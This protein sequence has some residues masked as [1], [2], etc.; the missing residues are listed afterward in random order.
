[1]PC[2]ESSPQL[3]T[4]HL[5]GRQE[6]DRT[7]DD[8]LESLEITGLGPD[9]CE[10]VLEWPVFGQMFDRGRIEALI[11]RSSSELSTSTLPLAKSGRGL[12]EED[13]PHLVEGFLIKVHTKNPVLDPDDLRGKAKIIAENGFSWDADSCLMVSGMPISMYIMLIQD[14]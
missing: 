11:F 4:N 8:I 13:A 12:K 6:A 9:V 3:S 10:D 7:T 2:L 14:S 5:T 1:M